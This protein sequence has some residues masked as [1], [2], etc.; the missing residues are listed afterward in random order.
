MGPNELKC[1]LYVQEISLCEVILVIVM[2][3]LVV[4]SSRAPNIGWAIMG[5]FGNFCSFLLDVSTF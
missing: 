4:G 2:D 5:E 1:T 3:V